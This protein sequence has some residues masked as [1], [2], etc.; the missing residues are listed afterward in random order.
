MPQRQHT[1]AV[2]NGFGV[3]V[4]RELW[5]CWCWL[6]LASPAIALIHSPPGSP[7][8]FRR[9]LWMVHGNRCGV[10]PTNEGESKRRDFGA[11]FHKYMSY[12]A[13]GGSP[14]VMAAT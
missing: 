9:F 10:R 14:K 3:V 12:I 2:L 6:H 13:F 5:A 1:L 11:L 4:L 7:Q 8:E